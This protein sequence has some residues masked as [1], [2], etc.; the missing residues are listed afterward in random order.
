[1]PFSCSRWLLLLATAMV[2]C[3]PVASAWGFASPSQSLFRATT[4]LKMTE[5]GAAPTTFREAEVLGLRLMQEGNYQEA[6]DG[7]YSNSRV[8][9]TFLVISTHIRFSL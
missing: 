6:L 9:T 1:M 2:V 8:Y 5:S 7:T 3:W 4:G